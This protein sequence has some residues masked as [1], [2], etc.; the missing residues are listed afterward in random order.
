MTFSTCRI[1]PDLAMPSKTRALLAK[2][3]ILLWHPGSEG[4][5]P[6]RPLLQEN[7]RAGCSDFSKSI[8]RYGGC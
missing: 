8:T 4:P 1:A 7:M 5:Q 2:T 3:M 6:F